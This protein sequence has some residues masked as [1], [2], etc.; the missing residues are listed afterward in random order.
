[1]CKKKNA[2]E[3]VAIVLKTKHRRI[4]LNLFVMTSFVTN[5]LKESINIDDKCGQ[6]VHVLF[7]ILRTVFDRVYSRL[8]LFFPVIS[9]PHFPFFS[10][11]FHIYSPFWKRP[12][13]Y[14]R[15][16]IAWTGKLNF[17]RVNPS[18]D[19]SLSI[20]VSVDQSRTAA[21][22]NICRKALGH[23][24]QFTQHSIPCRFGLG[25]STAF[26]RLGLSTAFYRLGLSTACTD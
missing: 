4:C 1:M 12:F 5:Y 15:R 11:S 13:H 17:P 9:C 23:L 26:Y 18:Q 7:F 3:W 25:L 8:H 14:G 2:D 21:L 6:R 10:I 24:M 20:F 19:R 16:V 22:F